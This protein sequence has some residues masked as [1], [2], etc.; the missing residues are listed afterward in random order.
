MSA[1]LSFHDVRKKFA[2]TPVLSN[3][4]LTIQSNETFGLAGMNGAGKTTLIRSLLDLCAIDGGTIEIFGANHR[5]TTAR[6]QLAFL[7]ERFTPPYYLNGTEF[8]HYMLRLYDRPYIAEE[9]TA[10][11]A[12]LDLTLTALR[13]PVRTYS[14]GMTQ[15]LGLA[16]VFLSRKPLLV[17]DE[18]LS[19]L[20][21]KARALVKQR[22][23]R[24]R[25]DGGTLFFS[26][27]TLSDVEQLCDRM[28]ILHH[29]EL[30]FVGTPAACRHRFD[31]DS[32][33]NAYLH[34]IG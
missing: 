11:F 15:K 30:Q 10:M 21:P 3:I 28:A 6:R 26:T 8:L 31:A 29:G 13:Q 32:M 34:C 25:A 1:A 22:L 27:H 33:E 14:K 20:D 7:P 23:Q 18:P 19:G 9:A 17:L 12:A 5:Q 4:E 2:Q 24:H 16:V